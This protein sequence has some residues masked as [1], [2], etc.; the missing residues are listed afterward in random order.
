MLLFPPRRRWCV[1][2]CASAVGEIGISDARRARA[3]LCVGFLLVC[4][5][6]AASAGAQSVV[7]TDLG[8]LPGGTSSSP[9]LVNALNVNGQVVGSADTA[10]GVTHAFSWTQL[11]GMIDLGTLGGGSSSATAVNANGQVVG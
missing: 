6:M 5:S 7:A 4:S 2:V 1:G 9:A 8:T 10:S 11:G 3:V